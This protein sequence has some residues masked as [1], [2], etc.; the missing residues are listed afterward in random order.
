LV[1]VLPHL[2][3]FIVQILAF[4]FLLLFQ[5]CSRWMTAPALQTLITW[6]HFAFH[7]GKDVLS[8]VESATSVRMASAEISAAANFL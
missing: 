8:A 1:A 3:H 6:E 4:I 2:G 7:F 5:G